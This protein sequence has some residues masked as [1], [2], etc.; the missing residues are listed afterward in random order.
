MS[1]HIVLDVMHANGKT[2]HYPVPRWWRIDTLERVIIVAGDSGDPVLRTVIPLDGVLSIDVRDTRRR[3]KEPEQAAPWAATR[4][5]CGA[6][7]IEEGA[8]YRTIQG[9]THRR[10][11]DDRRCDPF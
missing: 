11:G 1:G 2:L 5:A 7:E 8:V 3:S 10:P 4:C 9:Q 6:V